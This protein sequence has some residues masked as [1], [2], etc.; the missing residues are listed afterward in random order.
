[1][2][3]ISK[4]FDTT[5]EYEKRYFDNPKYSTIE[6]E[7]FLKENKC[8]LPK[9]EILDIGGSAGGN[10]AYLA[11]KYPETKFLGA[12]YNEAFIEMGKR[13]LKSSGI[14]NVS[15]EA[16]DWF[17]LPIS[18]KNRFDGVFNVHTMCCFKQLKPALDALI[19]L[20]P[21]WIAFNSLFYEGP[22]DVLIHIR[23]YV[24]RKVTDDDSDSDFNIFSLTEM[25]KYLAEHGYKL[26]KYSRFEIPADL[27]KPKGGERGTY[28]AKTEFQERA[29]FSGPV[30]LPWYFV[31][32]MKK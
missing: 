1:M 3:I 25:K 5:E 21:R 13:F 23:S 2:T 29:Q 15:L 30:Y 22:L 16:A 20:N 19:K 7:K 6:F 24:G 18:Y 11:K 12:D 8:I 27:P 31:V 14:K 4:K 9:T 28:T 17:N 26:F 10:V 32:A